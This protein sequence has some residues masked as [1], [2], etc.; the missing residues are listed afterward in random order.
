VGSRRC[1]VASGT[2]LAA[3]ARTKPPKLKLHDYGSCSKKHARDAVSLFVYGIGPDTNAGVDGWVY[4]VGNRLAT[5]GAADPSGP[6]GNGRLHAGARVTWFY[7]H[8]NVAK[9]SCQRT[10]RV[11]AQ[12]APA[13]TLRVH[14]SSYDDRGK[15]KPGAG[16]TVHAGDAVATADANGDATLLLPAGTY[17]VRAERSGAIRSFEETV[18]VG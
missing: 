13:G 3:L 8:M 6:F 17:A 11:K 18:G 1:A 12:P 7:C 15:S 16:A 4:K 5:A 10:L 2:A 9:H 14:V